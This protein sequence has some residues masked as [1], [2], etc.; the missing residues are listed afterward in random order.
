M[1]RKV[2]LV[3][4]IL[5]LILGIVTCGGQ[6]LTGSLPF[7]LFGSLVVIGIALLLKSKY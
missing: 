4:V 7:L 2:L 6:S 1:I 5:I 3:G